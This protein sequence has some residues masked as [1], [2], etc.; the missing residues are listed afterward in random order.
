MA[1]VTGLDVLNSGVRGAEITTLDFSNLIYS[2]GR[3]YFSKFKPFVTSAGPQMVN[4]YGYPEENF[5]IES[6]SAKKIVGVHEITLDEVRYGGQPIGTGAGELRPGLVPL[7]VR[8]MVARQFGKIFALDDKDLLDLGKDLPGILDKALMQAYGKAVDKTIVD[9]LTAPI[10]SI[11]YDKTNP[12]AWYYQNGSR[13]FLAKYTATHNKA[14]FVYRDGTWT[15]GSTVGTARFGPSAVY[16]IEGFFIDKGISGYR[17]VCMQL[18][19]AA[20]D[21]L[22][23]TNEGLRMLRDGGTDLIQFVKTQTTLAAGESIRTNNLGPASAYAA[24]NDVIDIAART[25]G[26]DHTSNEGVF[27]PAR[28]KH[29]SSSA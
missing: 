25:I 1:E 11:V 20:I 4:N 19:P 6:G 23:A 26:D 18:T 13:K 21:I 14:N 9:S 22:A 12:N 2:Y 10:P 17:P 8:L 7:S 29:D 24:A 3:D 16:K 15:S 28:T 27:I 5:K